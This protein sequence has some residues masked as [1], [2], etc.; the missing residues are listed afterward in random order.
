MTDEQRSAFWAVAGSPRVAGRIVAE[1]F[2]RKNAPP[3]GAWLATWSMALALHAGL[4]FWSRSTAPGLETWSAN[5]AMKVHN[6][7][8]REEV[9][10][11]APPPPVQAPEPPPPP[12]PIEQAPRPQAAVAKAPPRPRPSAKSPSDASAPRS[13]AR[14]GQV[15]ARATQPGETV[16]LTG[17][18]LVTGEARSYAGG[19]TAT[20]GTSRE[21]VHELPAVA[22]LRPV[23]RGS[24]KPTARPQ[25]ELPPPPLAPAGPDRSSQVSLLEGEWQCPWPKEADEEQIDEQVVTLRVKVRDDGTVEEA[26]LLQDPGRGFGQAALSCARRTRFNPARDREG[27]PIRSLSPPIRVHFTR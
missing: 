3:R 22:P 8:A 6:Q 25:S 24:P 9:M 14:A 17:F 20:G 12:R 2:G 13:L 26:W 15:I 5:L 21:A 4:W 23:E 10:E 19:L 27:N 16:D 11:L 18:D 1:V 7:L